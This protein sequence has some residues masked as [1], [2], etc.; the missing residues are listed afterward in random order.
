MMCIKPS[1]VRI[2]KAYK[3]LEITLFANQFSY[4]ASDETYPQNGLKTYHF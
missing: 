3:G 4:L 1:K 2:S